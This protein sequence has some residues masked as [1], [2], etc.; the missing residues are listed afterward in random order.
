MTIMNSSID[1]FYKKP[2][3]KQLIF[4]LIGIS[5]VALQYQHFAIR[6][7][8]MEDD[9]Y[10]YAQIAYNIGIN[11][12][13][14]FDGIHTTSGYHL[15]WGWILGAL[16]F[17][18]S[19]IT[20]SKSIHFASFLVLYIY[21]CINIGSYFGKNLVEKFILFSVPMLLTILMET[22]ILSILLLI[23]I[24]VFFVRKDESSRLGWLSV[25][26]IP[27]ARI[28]G[29]VILALPILYLFS[30]RE[31]RRL[32]LQLGG[33]LCL[34]AMLHFI[35]MYVTF[36]NLFSVSSLYKT[37]A[38]ISLHQIA[39]RNITGYT[40]LALWP[41]GP[42]A[43]LAYYVF[44]KARRYDYVAIS[45]G[46]ILFLLAHLLANHGFRLWYYIPTYTV[47]LF[48]I[49]QSEGLFKL[50]SYGIM[51]FFM[52]YFYRFLYDY[53]FLHENNIAWEKQ[54]ILELQQTVPP[55]SPIYQI[56][57]AGWTGY[58]SQRHII[59]GDGL[60]NDYDYYELMKDGNLQDY[61]K[62]NGIRYV[63]TNSTKYD[64]NYVGNIIDL[65]GLTVHSSQAELLIDLP[66]RVYGYSAF[67]LFGLKGD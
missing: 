16:S 41:L 35:L 5:I 20:D 54:F 64:K 67:R 11:H 56:D 22:L 34:G 53:R 60:V 55:E 2:V 61:L 37:S 17:V 13:S 25:F 19:V 9:S 44:L 1:E 4:L 39:T 15:L 62:D 43:A 24:N 49:F 21:L 3:V 45:T 31:T 10:F 47:L 42:L 40:K 18:V 12:M 7:G 52:F 32:S 63:I 65:N 51:L 66:D 48:L 26:L 14:S 57:G 23:F 50:L 38:E 6:S 30:N 28:D 33:L 29:V 59:N 36:G 58:F 27:L 8:F 46:A